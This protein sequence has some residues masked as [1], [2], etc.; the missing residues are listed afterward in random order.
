MQVPYDDP[1][2]SHHD[3]ILLAVAAPA[4]ARAVLA[5]VGGDPALAERGWELHRL[6]GWLDLVVTGVGKASAAGAVARVLGPH[7]GVVSLGIGGLLPG[8]ANLALGSVVVGTAAVFADEG[9]GEPGG[10]RTCADMGF[11][12]LPGDGVCGMAIPLD[13]AL[14]DCV[15]AEARARIATVSTCSGTDTLAAEVA[16]RTGALVEGMEGAAVA[17]VA[18]R[19]G[20]PAAELRVISNT[21][22]ERPAQRWD[23]KGALARLRDVARALGEPRA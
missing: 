11:P 1:V 10:F 16:R 6:G 15:K 19:L 5:G 14:A 7:A 20:V 8:G 13:A 17:L 2:P 4:E 22:G 9:S 23:I 21:T 12:P 3:R 18:A